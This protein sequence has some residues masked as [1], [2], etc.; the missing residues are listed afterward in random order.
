MI[1]A[2]IYSDLVLLVG[3]D[4]VV[5]RRDRREELGAGEGEAGLEL[6]HL[7][8]LHLVHLV[9][10]VLL[11]ERGQ[12]RLVDPLG[13][14]DEA[15]CQQDEHLLRLLVDLVILVGLCLEH[16]LGSLDVEKDVSEGPDGVSVTSHHHVGKA[17]TS[18]S[19]LSS[20]K[21]NMIYPT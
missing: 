3:V 20:R 19:S 17:E 2:E 6:R 1:D 11:P 16:G 15:D 14:E 7:A 18:D 9:R 5:C 8:P 10:V 13:M 4:G 12:Q 21:N